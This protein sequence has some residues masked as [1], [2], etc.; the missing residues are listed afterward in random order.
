MEFLLKCQF[1]KKSYAHKIIKVKASLRYHEKVYQTTIHP[2]F[3]KK[4]LENLKSSN[5]LFRKLPDYVLQQ[6]DQN[7]SESER[8]DRTKCIRGK[9]APADNPQC[10]KSDDMYS[11]EICQK[12]FAT[13]GYLMNHR[14]IH[15]EKKVKCL[16]CGKGFLYESHRKQHYSKCHGMHTFV[17]F[18]LTN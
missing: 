12:T 4:P 15:G 7:V 3:P 10:N 13:R 17:A 2:S 5:H 9:T 6:K 16:T 18:F 8:P 14:K 11:C 1:E